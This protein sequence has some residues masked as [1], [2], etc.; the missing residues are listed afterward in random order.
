M[1]CELAVLRPGSARG[2][3]GL[4]SLGPSASELRPRRF[5]FASPRPGMV[6]SAWSKAES[7]WGFVCV[8]GGRLVLG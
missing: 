4:R 8:A 3:A 5:G 2:R 7:A 1:W 6:R